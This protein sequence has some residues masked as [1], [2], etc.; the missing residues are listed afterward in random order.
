[1]RR[2]IALY[3]SGCLR[4]LQSE[5][6]AALRYPLLLHSLASDGVNGQGL[7][8]SMV[9]KPFQARTSARRGITQKCHGG[10]ANVRGKCIGGIA[11]GTLRV[12]ST[13]S[14]RR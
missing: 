3:H 14:V 1:M 2:S 5:R 8:M 11:K 10:T 13:S 9:A 4:T 7:W 6:A 12:D